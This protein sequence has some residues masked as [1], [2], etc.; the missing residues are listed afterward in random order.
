[1]PSTSVLSS[2]IPAVNAI[3]SASPVSTGPPK[4]ISATHPAGSVNSLAM[5]SLNIQL[6]NVK[7][8]SPSVHMRQDTGK[9]ILYYLGSQKFLCSF[10]TFIKKKQFAALII[11]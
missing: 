3:T 7:L 4:A 9:F 2:N 10:C 8:M 6:K 1:M 5:Q 11:D